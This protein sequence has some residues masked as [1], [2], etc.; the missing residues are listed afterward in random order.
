LDRIAAVLLLLTLAFQTG[1]YNRYAGPAGPIDPEDAAS[2][3]AINEAPRI[4]LTTLDGGTHTLRMP[5]VEGSN[6]TG[7]EGRRGAARTW[8]PLDSVV[9]T[10]IVERDH[11][12][13]VVAVGLVV[14]GAVLL[15]LFAT[16]L[17]ESLD[18]AP[19]F[20]QGTLRTRP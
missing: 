18:T 1:C 10:E 9:A 5:V 11:A 6:V 13:T 15:V 4:D 3:E 17:S 2:V 8:I 16:D 7:L 14:G 12:R 20:M 19:V